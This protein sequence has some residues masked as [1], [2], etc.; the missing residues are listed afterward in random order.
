MRLGTPEGVLTVPHQPV[1]FFV[2]S[3]SGVTQVFV[4]VWR[5][6]G[7]FVRHAF[8]ITKHLATW[9]P[10]VGAL[11][12]IGDKELVYHHAIFSLIALGTPLS[13]FTPEEVAIREAASRKFY[14][15]QVTV[16]RELHLGDRTENRRTSYTRRQAN[17]LLHHMPAGFVW[18][19]SSSHSAY[20]FQ[21]GGVLMVARPTSIAHTVPPGGPGAVKFKQVKPDRRTGLYLI[22]QHY[23]RP[24]KTKTSLVVAET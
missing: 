19:P 20:R 18:V 16:P 3:K 9:G 1:A 2:E 12:K 11:I 23:Y 13:W 8:D 22:E 21:E 24:D 17:A 14:P 10:S 4:H 7:R 6:T 15:K 5:P